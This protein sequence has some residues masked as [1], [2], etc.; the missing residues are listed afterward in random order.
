MQFYRQ[1]HGAANIFVYKS[2]ENHTNTADTN[3]GTV[4]KAIFAHFYGQVFSLSLFA[5]MCQVIWRRPCE[6]VNDWIGNIIMLRQY[7]GSLRFKQL[8]LYTPTGFRS[9]ANLNIPD[10][11]SAINKYLFGYTAKKKQGT[12]DK[13]LSDDSV[14]T[15]F[16]SYSLVAPS[17]F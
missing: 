2:A 3:N 14:L 1:I 5:K 16:H 11:M 15:I 8:Q 9:H 13:S 6:G 12:F 4:T 17:T 7:C 10:L